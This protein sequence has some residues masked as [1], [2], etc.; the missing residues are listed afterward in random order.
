MVESPHIHV[1]DPGKFLS[2]WEEMAT[3]RLDIFYCNLYKAL[4]N[5]LAEG[6]ISLSVLSKHTHTHTHKMTRGVSIVAESGR[7]E[8]N[9]TLVRQESVAIAQVCASVYSMCMLLLCKNVRPLHY[10]GRHYC[11]LSGPGLM[12]SHLTASQPCTKQAA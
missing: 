9:W 2:Q 3:D 10:I 5:M 6:P 12:V 11:S 1:F 7:P 4:K 8:T